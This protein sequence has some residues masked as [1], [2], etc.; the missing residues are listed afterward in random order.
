M[1][2]VNGKY[3]K[4]GAKNTKTPYVKNKLVRG[5]MALNLHKTRG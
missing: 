4:N 3:I 5:Y 2:Y 1:L